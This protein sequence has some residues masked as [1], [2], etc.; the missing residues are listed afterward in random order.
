MSRADLAPWGNELAD[1]EFAAALAAAAVLTAAGRYQPWSQPDSI[2]LALRLHEIFIRKA[3]E[4]VEC[5]GWLAASNLGPARTLLDAWRASISEL[6]YDDKPRLEILAT[7]VVTDTAWVAEQLSLPKVQARSVYVADDWLPADADWNWPLLVG[8]LPDDSSQTLRSALEQDHWHKELFD[9][10]QTSDD[11]KQ[12]DLLLVPSDAGI[13]LERVMAARPPI[14]ANCI[15]VFRRRNE[16]WQA[17]KPL[18]EALATQTEASGVAIVPLSSPDQAQWFHE[19]VRAL[20][21]DQAIDLSLFEAS[22]V[23]DGAVPL[24]L[25]NRALTG[26]SRVSVQAERMIGRVLAANGG[27]APLVVS[28]RLADALGI[29]SG[30]APS[31]DVA[32]RVRDRIPEIQFGEESG[33]ATTVADF[34]RAAEPILA[35]P[36]E[37]AVRRILAH[38]FDISQPGQPQ[39]LES[40]FRAGATHD[41]EVWIGPWELGAIAADER[42]PEEVL[43]PSP[44]GHRLTV[45]LTE[46]TSS[47]GAQLQTIRLPAAGRSTSCHF[48]LNPPSSASSIEARITV[49]YRNRILQTALLRGAVIPYDI[50]AP[51]DTTIRIEV[52]AVLRPSIGDLT[53]RQPFDAALIFNQ[54]ADSTPAVTPIAGPHAD[55]RVMVGMPEVARQIE[56][57]LTNAARSPERYDAFDTPASLSLLR[58]LANQ[59]AALREGLIKRQAVD[60]ALARATRIQV[61]AA[62]PEEVIPV[63]L[64]YDRTPPSSTA[65]LC[66]NF[67]ARVA[68][69]E[70]G[71][72]CP[73]EAQNPSPYVC[74]LAFWCANKIIER[75][76]TDEKNLPADF[77]LDLR[78]KTEPTKGRDILNGF[79]TAL[80]AGSAKVD[81]LAG[82]ATAS[83][84]KKVL[85]TLLEV[86]G[87]RAERVDTWQDWEGRVAG[88][89]PSLLLL[90]PHTLQVLGVQGMEIGTDAQL[91]WTHLTPAMIGTKESGVP[92]IVLLLGCDTAMPGIAFQSFVLKFRE[93]GA[94][95][96]LGTLAAVLGRYAAPL[97][98]DLVRALRQAAEGAPPSEVESDEA[99]F[100]YVVRSVRRKLMAKGQVMAL[101][102]SAYGDAQ[103]RLASVAESAPTKTP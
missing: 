70:C 16:T 7:P 1:D 99:T 30:T 101:A 54:L 36:P 69:G 62:K 25:A 68:D 98:E 13:A 4:P 94:A 81:T 14:R 17:T 52:G 84:L 35:P 20:A 79:S 91:A 90:L 88:A 44:R 22:T 8:L 103:W 49:L 64:L 10:A 60:D 6:P 33:A 19:L 3:G 21:H 45:I 59:G 73:G 87:E 46:P 61:L 23:I 9:L 86:T 5:A 97:A 26:V 82:E 12:F 95:I 96:V 78:L 66:P 93:N 34:A 83:P 102:L 42:F 37:K 76:A 92:P 47:P 29:V 53:G 56:E 11:L 71:D 55:L 72:E 40:A 39:K 31:S 67:P 74:P 24:L 65:Q 2:A 18:L 100:G 15:V 27:E 28:G 85:D 50:S 57:E 75:H 58:T 38:V 51:P 77:Q 43:P 80:F 63:E 89:H 48:V 41:I 32:A